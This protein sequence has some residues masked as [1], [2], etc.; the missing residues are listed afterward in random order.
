V[1]AAVRTRRIF[2]VEDV[3]AIPSII[4]AILADAD[5]RVQCV[6]TGCDTLARLLQRCPDLLLLNLGPPDIDD[7]SPIYPLSSS[8]RPNP[9]NVVAGWKGQ[10]GYIRMGSITAAL[11]V[12]P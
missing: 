1:E 8:A 9:S 6:T 2:Y 10:I 5:Y 7:M 11:R 12:G 3:P 4:A